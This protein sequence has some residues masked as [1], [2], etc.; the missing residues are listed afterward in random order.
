MKIEHL[1]YLQEI[2]KCKSIS[3]AAKQLYIGQTTLSA[4][5]K[6][7]EDELGVKIFRRVPSGVLPTEDGEKILNLSKEIIDRYN[8]MVSSYHPSDTPEKRI[9]FVGNLTVCRY[10][11]V[12]LMKTVQTVSEQASIIFHEVNRRKVLPMILDGISNIGASVLDINLEASGY[13]DQAV[14]N[15]LEFIEIG[16]DKFYL[17]VRADR[18]EYAGQ[19]SVDINTLVN[20]RYVAPLNHALVPNG[21]GFNEAFRR[22]HCV[23]TLSSPN[24]VL[25]AVYECDMIAILTGRTIVDD[26]YIR[27]GEILAIPLTGF[28]CDNSMGIYLISQKRASLNSFEKAVYDALLKCSSQTPS[29]IG[30]DNTP[31]PP[32]VSLSEY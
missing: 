15:G 28:P 25:K 19:Q 9:H 26:P 17:C 6:S 11:S 5:V 4:I 12:Y 3:A 31:Y 8:E 24:L 7:M 27:T 30:G 20:E 16:T 14:K 1:C 13:R 10:F 22:L 18:K 2:A 29:F 32:I 23:A 21:T